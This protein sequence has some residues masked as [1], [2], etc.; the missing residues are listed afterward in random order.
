MVHC[1]LIAARNTSGPITTISTNPLRTVIAQSGRFSNKIKSPTSY[2][3]SMIQFKQTFIKANS[4]VTSIKMSIV[5]NNRMRYAIIMGLYNHLSSH[6]DLLVTT[7]YNNLLVATTLKTD[8]WQ[9]IRTVLALFI[10][11]LD[12]V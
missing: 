1:P 4:G 2:T 8:K 7:Y 6:T 3:T 9:Q 10:I 5:I 12:D 11:F